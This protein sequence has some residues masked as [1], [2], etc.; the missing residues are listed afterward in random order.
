MTKKTKLIV[1]NSLDEVPD[2][3]TEDEEREFWWT[4]TLSPKLMN[5]LPTT[6]F[7]EDEALRL[8]ELAESSTKKR[9]VS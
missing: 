2:F 1:I 5:S 8:K 6:T 7:E 3:A 9:K 4:H